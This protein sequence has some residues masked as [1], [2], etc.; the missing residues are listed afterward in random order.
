[1][2]LPPDLPAPASPWL[3]DRWLDAILHL[4]PRGRRHLV[5]GRRYARSGRVVNARVAAGVVSGTVLGDRKTPYAVTIMVRPIAEDVWARALQTIDATDRLA[6]QLRLGIVPPTVATLVETAGDTLW[7]RDGYALRARCACGTRGDSCRHVVALHC[8][9]ADRLD[10]EPFLLFAL[11]GCP[12]HLVKRVLHGESWTPAGETGNHGPG[13]VS[14]DTP[15]AIPTPLPSTHQLL[16]PEASSAAF[17][18]WRVA[19]PELEPHLPDDGGDP[20]VLLTQLG[21]PPGWDGDTPLRELL[22]PI[23]RAAAR[24]ARELLGE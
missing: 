22:T 19:P 7:P 8:W 21:D 2:P 3:G 20:Q 10:R 23:Y 11:R 4:S 13:D 16:G 6:L 18:A 9:L 5:L 17:D 15:P 12:E 1:M 24:H 14:P